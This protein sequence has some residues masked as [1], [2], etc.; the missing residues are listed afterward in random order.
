MS[1]LPDR[2]SA[3]EYDAPQSVITATAQAREK[4]HARLGAGIRITAAQKDILG[5]LATHQIVD[6]LPTGEIYVPGDKWRAVLNEAFDPMGWALKPVGQPVL[7]LHQKGEGKSVMYREVYLVV[8]RCSKCFH[9]ISAC[10]CKVARKMEEVSLSMAYGAQEYFPGSKRMTF[11]DAAEGCMTNGLMRC[12]KAF[13]VFANIWDKAWATAAREE[14]GV[15]V[16]VTGRDRTNR[17]EWRR[18]DARYFDGENGLAHGSPNADRYTPPTLPK[19]GP[20][21]APPPK[22]A[23]AE[24]KPGPAETKPPVA[25]T[26]QLTAGTAPPVDETPE[27]AHMAEKILGV[28]AVKYGEDGVPKEYW[29]LSTDQGEYYTKDADMYKTLENLRQRGLRVEVMSEPVNTKGGVRRRI[30]EFAAVTT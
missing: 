22:P 28:R 13:G 26:K 15:K 2:V 17:P 4:L 7:D 19:A 3:V 14:V 6:L 12:C 8:S 23:P 24:T 5:R 29:I 18:L 10:E 25:E 11:D 20:R 1:D 27:P 9:S 16:M 30:V 21:P